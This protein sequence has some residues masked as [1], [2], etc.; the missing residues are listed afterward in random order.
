VTWRRGGSDL[1]D[2]DE[3]IVALLAERA[4]TPPADLDAHLD[5]VRA[6]ARG[7]RLEP[8]AAE[9]V[10]RTLLGAAP[11][12][13]AAAPRAG[14][15][16]QASGGL[17]EESVT[18]V[19]A[20]SA[21]SSQ[22]ESGFSEV[23]SAVAQ[24]ESSIAAIASSTGRAAEIAGTAVGQ[25]DA[26]R[27]HVLR[28]QAA[29]TQIGEIVQVISAITQQSR[30]LA[31][32]ATIEA[33]RAGE[34]GRGFAVVAHE[35]KQL[36]ART[37]RA[38]DTVA[39]QITAVQDE[40]TAAVS[41]IDAVNGTIAEIHTLQESA[42]TA[43]DDQ[44][45]QVARIVGSVD[46][47]ARGSQEIAASTARLAEAQ[48]SAYLRTALATA[49]DVL[50]RHGDVTLDTTSV[51]W[52]VTD[53]VTGRTRSAVLPRLLVGR[54]WLGQNDDPRR[55]TAVVDEVKRLVGGTA[56]V[57]QRVGPDGE[58]LRV[59]TNVVTKAGRRAVGTSIPPRTADDAPNRVLATVLAG[60][61]YFGEAVVVDRPYHAAYA[62]L[63]GSD[64]EVVGM[65]YVGL[66][67]D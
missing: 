16:P 35:V 1:A 57:F 50:A 9:R 47:A 39:G 6:L 51:T 32:N 49:L 29:G 53:Q 41:A 62:P 28:L 17:L 59:A 12:P 26:V 7:T 18:A 54:E 36:A 23:V 5:R 33:T 42:V 44:S 60:D 21:A 27:E 19:T 64:G 34:A 37:A 3:R 25:A 52:S 38:A 46:T 13:R 8:A 55:T 58:M 15:A 2:L 61:T 48:R 30:M 24:M 66:P 67:K 45:A 63:R 14:A 4:A 56:T 40:T 20:L 43:V 31:L 22:V 65:L 11:A 10:Y